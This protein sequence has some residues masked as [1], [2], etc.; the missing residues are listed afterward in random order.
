MFAA[1]LQ[2]RKLTKEEYLKLEKMINQAYEGEE[3]KKG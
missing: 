2:D 3:G 1:F